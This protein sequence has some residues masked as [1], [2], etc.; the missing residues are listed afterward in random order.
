MS[1][2]CSITAD[3][4]YSANFN[5]NASSAGRTALHYAAEA[6][7]YSAVVLL[8]ASG[9]FLGLKDK[10]GGHRCRKAC[11]HGHARMRAACEGDA[12]SLLVQRTSS[13]CSG[14]T[15]M[16]A[17]AVRTGVRPCTCMPLLPCTRAC[18]DTDTLLLRLRLPQ[19]Q[20][21][22]PTGWPGARATTL[23]RSCSRT[24]PCA[25]VAARTGPRTAAVPRTH[26]ATPCP[27]Q[28]AAVSLACSH[29][30]THS[31]TW[32]RL[33]SRSRTPLQSAGTGGMGCW[34]ASVD[35]ECS[36]CPPGVVADA[37]RSQCYLLYLFVLSVMAIRA[38]DHNVA[39][40]DTTG[41]FENAL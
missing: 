11:A 17:R 27:P 22:R 8:L 19:L 21:G 24:R 31:A 34:P 25:S 28:R 9:A 38:H 37:P 18:G 7:S 30:S 40:S 3:S 26:P 29:L 35:A 33:L 41:W 15:C 10:A 12:G 32:R 14:G 2:T 4:I 6:G 1:S 39:T 5:T 16:H 23:W 20:G 36:A 13:P